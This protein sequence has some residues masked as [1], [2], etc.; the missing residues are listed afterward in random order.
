MDFLLASQK[1]H[2]NWIV[3]KQ[4][5]LLL[6]RMTA[7]AAIVLMVAQPILRD[8]WGDLLGN[9]QTHHVVLLDDSYSMSDRGGRQSVYQRAKQ[10]IL[11]LANQAEQQGGEHRLSL[12]RTSRAASRPEGSAPDFVQQLI[13]KPLLTKLDRQLNSLSPSE[14]SADA[15]PGLKAIKALFE[16][17]EDEH[18]IVYLISDF[19]VPQWEDPEGPRNHLAALASP[20]TKIRLIHCTDAF[21]PNLAITRLEPQAGVRAAGVEFFMEVEVTNFGNQELR[22]IPLSLT[23][24]GHARPGIVFDAIGAGESITRRFRVNFVAPGEHTL[25]AR[26]E[27]DCVTTDN[28]WYAVVEVPQSVPTLIIDGTSRARDGYFLSMALNPGGKIQTG[29]SPQIEPVSFLR[30][31]DQLKR[32]PTIFLANIGHLEVPEVETLETFVKQGGGL[33]IFLGE[34]SIG[35]TITEKLYRSGDG[36]FPLPVTISTDLLAARESA[37]PDIEATQHPIFQMFLTMRNNPLDGVRIKRYFQVPGDWQPS[38]DS[39]GQVIARLRNGAPLVV[40]RSLGKGRVVTFLTKPSPEETN[41]GSWNDWARNYSYVPTLLMLQGYLAAE[42]FSID[43]NHVASP[44]DVQLDASRYHPQVRFSVPDGE[45]QQT[46]ALDA[47]PSGTT[48]WKAQL[49]NTSQAGLYQAELRTFDGQPEKRNYAYNV[50]TNESELDF[51]DADQLAA[52]LGDLPVEILMAAELRFSPHDLAGYN[53]SSTLFYVVVCI[54][55]FELIL[56]YLASYHPPRREGIA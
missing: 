50:D 43:L 25:V 14:T 9:S 31:R 22:D 18:R 17:A 37:T 42:R 27:N 6:L 34:Q 13:D 20:Q 32:F 5:L 51:L 38:P 21:R 44:L 10:V 15:I 3:L 39:S 11:R 7:I 48:H 52:R 35:R 29:I 30:K 8:Q 2:K 33:G 12:L 4:L 1:R 24:D 19:R 41:L 16:R 40:E 47:T 45:H 23:E 54:L 55:L 53:L 28:A 56:A 36:L 26:L 49:A 46:V